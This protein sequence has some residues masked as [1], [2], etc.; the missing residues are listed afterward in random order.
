M[1]CHRIDSQRGAIEIFQTIVC[2]PNIVGHP[3]FCLLAVDKRPHKSRIVQR[4]ICLQCRGIGSPRRLG[5]GGS[6]IGR[7]SGFGH[8][9]DAQARR[10][11][12]DCRNIAT[13]GAECTGHTHVARRT[14][15]IGTGV[16]HHIE[17]NLRLQRN[18][19]HKSCQE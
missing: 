18:C 3:T 17:H 11:V 15:N 10:I 7:Q 1:R 12:D 2:K 5:F 19:R 8:T 13:Q 9:V 6:N 4:K 16:T 14:H